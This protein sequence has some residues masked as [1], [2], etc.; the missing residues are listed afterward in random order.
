MTDFP[1]LQAAAADSIRFAFPRIRAQVAA[2]DERLAAFY[3]R[4][5][6]DFYTAAP[7]GISQEDIAQQE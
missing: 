1:Q 7:D 3:F 5:V 2:N 4:F 6:A